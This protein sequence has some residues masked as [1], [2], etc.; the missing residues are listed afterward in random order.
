MIMDE[1]KLCTLCPRACRVD[2]EEKKGYCGVSGKN[3]LLARA[4]LHFWEEPFISG[5]G[6]SGAVFF[7]GCS[8]HC[9]YCQNKEISNGRIGK[10]VTVPRLSEIFLSLQDQGAHNINLVTPTHY[11]LQIREAVHMARAKGMHIPVVYNCSG[12]ESEETLKMLSDTVDIYLTDFKYSDDELAENLSKCRDYF[13]VAARALDEMVRQQ[14]ACIVDKEGMMTKGVVVR[15]LLLPGHVK[16]SEGVV[17]YVYETYHDQVCL[18]LMNQYTP[19]GEFP[20]YPYLHRKV[21]KREYNK[22]VEF[23]ISLGVE[24]AFIQEGATAKESF[25]PAFDYEGI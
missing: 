19:M 4:A 2:R 7:T 11:S 20:E 17:R 14:P 16:N 18:S 21:T 12:Y 15:N 13:T 3:V 8:L 24:N 22:L 9:I 5:T 25:I 10:E 23:A 6:G 1:S